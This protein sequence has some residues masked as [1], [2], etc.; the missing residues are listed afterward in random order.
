MSKR[1]TLSYNG[2][3]CR[4]GGLMSGSEFFSEEELFNRIS[5]L[6]KWETTGFDPT[7]VEIME[8]VLTPRSLTSVTKWEIV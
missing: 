3:E 5:R 7:K 2:S 8:V 4:V 1:Y 6:Q